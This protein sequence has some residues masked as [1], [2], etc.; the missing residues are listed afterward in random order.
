MAGDEG[1]VR[2]VAF[3]SDDYRRACALRD[4]VLRAPLGLRLYD[5]DL[6]AERDQRHFGWF[7]LDGALSA[8]A[9]AAPLGAGAAKIRQMAVAPDRRGRGLGRRL[10]LEVER[11][12]AAGGIARVELHARRAAEGFYRHCGYESE[13]AGFVE[14]TIPHVKMTKRLA[15]RRADEADA[16][17][18]AAG[19]ADE[20]RALP[21][22]LRALR[23][24]ILRFEDEACPWIRG[25]M[26]T[27]V[28]RD[29]P[30]L[31]VVLKRAEILA[32]TLETMRPIPLS[33]Q[34]LV[35][36]AF[37]RLRVHGGVG[38][39]DAWR[40]QC[41]HPEN[42]GYHD[43]WPLPDAVGAE[44]AWWKGRDLPG[45]AFRAAR[46]WH[47]ELLRH[48]LAHPHG[49]VQGHTLPD[50][51]VLLAAGIGGLR[52]RIAA[53][54]A[55]P[56]TAAQADQLRAMD[57]CLE[58]LARHARG[59][60]EAARQ[61]A[62]SATDAGAR[63]RF[64]EAAANAEAVAEAPP[65]TF[66]QALQLLL[67][68]NFAD[69]MDTPGDAASFG[70][71]DQLLRPFYDADLA[72]GRLTR[73]AAF[74]WVAQFIAL[75]WAVQPS[76]NLTV[77][78]VDPEGADATHDLSYLFL[79]AMEATELVV[80][81]SVRLHRGSPPAFV[82]AVARC[83]RRGFGRPSVYSDDVAI[84][85]LL[86][87]GVAPEDARDY[88]PLGCVE[89][90]IPGRTSFRTMCMGLNLPKILELTL[91]RGRSLVNSETVWDDV[92][93]AFER[94]DDVLAAYRANVR[95]VVDAGVEIIRED[96]RIEPA[97]FPRPW[98]SA[99]SRGGIEDALDVT[100][101]QPRYDAVGV[102]LDGL[103]DIVNSLVAVRRLVYEER[104]L[105]LDGLRDA[106]RS[107]WDGHEALRRRVLHDLPRFGQD[108]PEIL[109]L[110]RDEAAHY[111]AAFD[112][113]RTFHGGRFWP[114]IFGVS[115]SLVQDHAPKTGALPSGRRAGETLAMSLQPAG[116]GAQGTLTELLGAC[117][118]VDFTAF[119]GGISNVQELD[120]T[121]FEGAAGRRRLAQVIRAFFDLG[122]MEIAPN[123][124]SEETLRAAQRDPDRHAFVMVRL[125]GLSARFVD[126]SPEMQEMVIERVRAAGR[127]GRD[128]AAE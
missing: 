108:A 9:T 97:V 103:A 120:P 118:A 15:V 28:Y 51:G 66:P 109:A 104:S 6:S 22:D 70:R 5:E 110:A 80:D 87:K 106:L 125:F 62:A 20:P 40:I 10:L 1:E 96:E 12:L 124:L 68:S 39:A 64:A 17:G 77:G 86:A 76:N 83:V 26:A 59:G 112:R 99:L 48:G 23:E 38:D 102:T 79:E 3:G 36:V 45:R 37:R 29:E 127:R 122:G 25:R 27:R 81:L 47:P 33:G 67:F 88:A 89:I 63:A 113:H 72:A 117:A 57:R 4:Q 55:A 115:T 128:G 34:R 54:Q 94:F 61:A 49:Q 42:W 46:E 14:V 56:C 100:A 123:F 53:R 93:D 11:R 90:M 84:P 13:G 92:S 114:M 78:G 74:E 50:H 105:P 19:A 101:G 35:G 8:C 65:A 111:A 95:R 24:R 43:A 116:A 119:A 126:L 21:E 44:L 18:R 91:N 82:D 98:L 16:S 71:I 69:C 73:E 2:E 58:G 107:N 32:R 121:H 75:R 7:D 52:A 30:G 60:A 31:P 41:R 85:A